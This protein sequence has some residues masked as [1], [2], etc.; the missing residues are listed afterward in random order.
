[1]KTLICAFFLF[2]AAALSSA[3]EMTNGVFYVDNPVEC[4]LIQQ[5]GAI[6]TNTI[7][8]GRT[9]TVGNAMMEMTTGPKTLFYFAGGPLVEVSPKA[10]ISVNLFDR[11]VKN[12]GSTPRKA[13][14]GACNLSLKFDQGEY[15]VIYPNTDP[16]SSLT[17]TTP[18]TAYEIQGGKFYFRITDRSAIVYVL[19]GMMNVHGDKKVDKTDKGKL[20][21]AVPFVDPASGLNDKVVTSIKPVKQEETDKFA[22]PIIL[23]EKKW[24]DVQFFVLEGKVV[25]VWM[26]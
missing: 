6:T 8:N 5:N 23:A 22:T 26:K 14:F 4:Q 25:G 17:I 15:C 1:M 13:E 3:A 12:L 19:E 2:V 9:I 10:T 21:I 16:N 18:Y 11:E 7:V 24:A 20:A